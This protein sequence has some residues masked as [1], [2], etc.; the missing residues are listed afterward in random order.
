MLTCCCFASSSPF[1]P[2]ACIVVYAIYVLVE[3]AEC[4]IG[5]GFGEVVTYSYIVVVLVVLDSL[6]GCLVDVG[7][8]TGRCVAVW[9]C[10]G[11]WWVGRRWV[12]CGGLV[13]L[14]CLQGVWCD[15]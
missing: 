1:T 11:L 12:R 7:G 8:C 15:L 10:C 4:G 14:V 2:F 6:D 5:G 3:E 9:G 13:I